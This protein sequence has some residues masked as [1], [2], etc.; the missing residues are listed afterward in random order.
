MTNG[1]KGDSTSASSRELM[2]WLQYE[3]G[4]LPIVW[5]NGLSATIDDLFGASWDLYADVG[6]DTGITVS[7]LIPTTQ[8]ER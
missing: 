7:N 6:T 2:L 3:G 8:F 1:V 4:Q 5:G